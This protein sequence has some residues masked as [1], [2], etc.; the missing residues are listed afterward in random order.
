MT[1][2]GIFVWGI[3]MDRIKF[4]MIILLVSFVTIVGGAFAAS[5]PAAPTPLSPGT[6][7][8]PGQEISTLTPTLQWSV[9]S[10]ADY[11]ALAISKYPYGS[12]NIVY[13][14]Q[15]V[16]GNSIQV[17]NG[18]LIFGEKYRWN[19]QAHNSAGWSPISST[20]YFSTISSPVAAFSATPM[21]GPAPLTVSFVDQS[22]GSPA[23]W[24]WDFG[25]GSP[26]SLDRNPSH[27][28]TTPNTYTV[29]LAVSNSAGGS[30]A[31]KQI[32]VT[33]SPC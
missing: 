12:S 19:M 13:N 28:Y 18:L 11:Y 3:S 26:A 14:P 1:I 4:C 27:T 32:V 25:D 22:T 7:S 33:A 6:S 20:L 15:Q 23:G 31:S 2:C 30:V 16:Y 10:G 8:E 17:P 21:S 9:V 5:P 24:L 29:R